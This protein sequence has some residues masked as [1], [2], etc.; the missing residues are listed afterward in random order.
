MVFECQN[1]S[2]GVVQISTAFPTDFYT[3]ENWVFG[4]SCCENAIIRGSV[5]STQHLCVTDRQTNI[6]LQ[7][8]P[9]Y[10]QRRMGK[11][12]EKI[13]R[14]IAEGHQLLVQ[15]HLTTVWVKPPRPPTVFWN[16][17]PNGCLINFLHTYYTIVSTLEYKF[18]F[19]YL[20]LWQS[21]AILSATT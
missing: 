5:V 16:F 4:L 17:F 21:Y 10:T 13:T 2:N 12:T 7:H 20:Q 9:R 11:N 3:A 1:T 6:T 8:M 15:I 14:L 18:L 19:K